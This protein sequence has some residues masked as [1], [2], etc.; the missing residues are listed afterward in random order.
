MLS[1]SLN[2]PSEF[3]FWSLFMVSKYLLPSSQSLLHWLSDLQ[4]ICLEAYLD[5]CIVYFDFTTLLTALPWDW[6]LHGTFSLHPYLSLLVLGS[7]LIIG[8]SPTVCSLMRTSAGFCTW[9]EETLAIGTCWGSKGWRAALQ[10]GIWG[11]LLSVTAAGPK[12]MAWS[13]VR[14]GD[15]GL[16]KGCVPEDGGHGTTCP[17]QWAQPWAARPQ[18]A[19]GQCSL[20]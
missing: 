11:D 15:G 3:P 5:C 12:G 14:R 6:T 8:H 13:C 10:K 18:G 19:L 7:A 17:G 1:L 4:A 9:E 16:G 2:F 20:I